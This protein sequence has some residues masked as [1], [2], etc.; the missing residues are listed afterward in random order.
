[1]P[2]TDVWATWLRTGR[3]GGSAAMRAEN[4]SRL[5]AVRDQIL[6]RAAIRPGDTVLD[7]GTG[8]GLLGLEA[9]QRSAPDGRVIFSDI[10]EPLLDDC[11][12]AVAE[13]A[14][15]DRAGFVLASATDRAGFVL[16]SATDLSEIATA[17]VDVLVER[18]VLL[19]IEDRARAFSEYHRVLRPG[20]RVSLGEP[21]NSWMGRDRPGYLWGYDV[22]AVIDL[23]RKLHDEDRA[24]GST[25]DDL[26]CGFDDRDLVAMARAAGF[27]RV[28][29]HTE[30]ALAPPPARDDLDVFLDTA[31]NPLAPT[32]R[33][34]MAAALTAGEAERFTAV[35]RDALHEGRGE[36]R[37]AMTYLRAWR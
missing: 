19:F 14:V 13:V 20:G 7:V 3:D 16:A 5:A 4:L 18:A 8:Q 32:T 36:R 17:S 31:P 23:E 21:L 11:R 2:D 25:D 15:T 9:L 28:E 27:E 24:E 1:M 22:T 26:L 10:S 37:H 29:T 34:L 35:L 30:L 12:S 33:A 6:E